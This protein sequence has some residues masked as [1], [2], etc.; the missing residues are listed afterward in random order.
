[1]HRSVIVDP[2]DSEHAKLR[3]LDCRYTEYETDN[4]LMRTVIRVW[5]I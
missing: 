4:R 5:Q 2:Q 3:M 1:M